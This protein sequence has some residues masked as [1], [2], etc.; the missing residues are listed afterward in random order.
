MSPWC[1]PRK[2]SEFLLIHSAQLRMNRCKGR[3]FT[4]K[5]LVK[6]RSIGRSFDGRE[7]RWWDTFMVD[8]VK[9]D[10]FEE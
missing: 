8:I 6:V 5:L 2:A 7:V 1:D 3:L 9:V 4:R 10:I